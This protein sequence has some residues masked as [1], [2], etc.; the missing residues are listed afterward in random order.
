MKEK[1]GGVV[2]FSFI[3]KSFYL[4]YFVV[5]QTDLQKENRGL[6]RS[7]INVKFSGG[8]AVKR[9]FVRDIFT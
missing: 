6:S 7:V 1:S 8:E 5:R 2:L 9:I 3:N 4:T